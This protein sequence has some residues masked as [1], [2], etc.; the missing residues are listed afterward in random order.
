M[1]GGDYQ[2]QMMRQI[3]DLINR[4][5]DLSRQIE[6]ERKEHKKEKKELNERIKKLENKVDTLEKENK[7]LKDENTR[8]KAQLNKDSSNSS[9]PSSTNGYKKVI[10]NRREKSD[11]NQGGQKGHKGSNLDKKKLKKILESS[12]TK[13]NP[14]IEINK[15][16]GNKNK[17]PHKCTVIDIEVMV[18][19]TDYLYYPNEK[20][21]YNIPQNHKRAI[22]YG[23]NIKAIAVEL[24]YEAYNST[25]TVKN[26]ISSLT[27]N[28]IEV[29]KG[30]LINWSKEISKKLDVEIEKIEQELLN[31][32]YAN[33][34]ESQIKINGKL[35]SEICACNDKYTRMW[36]RDNKKH[37]E[38][39]RIPFFNKYMGII[40]KDGIDIYN[41]FGIGF[42]QC[43]SHIQRYL[44]GIYDNIKHKY[45]KKMAEFLTK[46]NNRRNELKEKGIKSFGAGEYEELIKEFETILYNWKHEWM[47]DENNGLYDE[48]RKL[49][50]RF[51]EDE[52]EQILYFLKDFKVPS[53]NNQAET[54]QRNIKI[55]Q[56]I[57]KFRSEDGAEIYAIN[58]SCINTYKKH[59]INVYQALVS[60]FKDDVVIA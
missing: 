28:T 25:D 45:P 55:K 60:A 40:V 37:E 41:G 31:S 9:K 10:T 39:E 20:G 42:S 30:T 33:C 14:T 3:E 50:T 27:Y 43:I 2:N 48:E 5:D 15:N 18:T 12:K 29:S 34:D 1:K 47:R 38:L 4:C 23:D 46:C 56:K 54:D 44:K 19:V 59:G 11:K 49:L 17:K 16:A 35:Y 57:G 52:R 24:M 6:K 7:K 26:V 36:T 21:E 53:T 32:Y 51:E 58:R 8:L 22:V 13:V